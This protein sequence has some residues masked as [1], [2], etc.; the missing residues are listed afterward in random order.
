MP[1]VAAVAVLD[2]RLSAEQFRPERY[3]DPAVVSLMDRVE[4]VGD[5]GLDAQYPASWPSWA[6][7]TT[8][9]GARYRAQVQHPRGDPA[10][11]LT[12]AELTA[13]FSDL[14]GHC[15]EPGRRAA[16][17]DAVARLPEADALDT[18]LKL[19]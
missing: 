5:A 4:C 10:N 18:M 9:G 12:G 1:F 11:P 2:G 14:T 19:A 17:L 6:E 16:L 15:Y 13:K 3:A 8:A 7:V